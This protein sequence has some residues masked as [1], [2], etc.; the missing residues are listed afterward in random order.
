METTRPTSLSI[1]L[2]PR[3]NEVTYLTLAYALTGASDDTVRCI[4]GE[5]IGD[6]D[7]GDYEGEDYRIGQVLPELARDLDILAVYA[8]ETGAV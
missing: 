2:A 4:L 6:V 7:D 1:L 8:Q 3:S 5:L